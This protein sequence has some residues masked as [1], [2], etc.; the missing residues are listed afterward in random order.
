[1]NFPLTRLE[2]RYWIW[3]I[4][5][6]ITWVGLMQTIAAPVDLS[7][8][9]P[10]ANRSVNFAKDVQP[11]LEKSCLKCHNSEKA[12]GK[13]TLDTREHALKGGD[14]GPD[15]IIG[16]SAKSSLMHFTARLVEDSEMP[17]IGKGDPLTSEQLGI[18]R[19]WI[20]QGVKWPQEIVLKGEEEMAETNPKVE[21]MTLPP[22]AARKVDFVKD[23]QPIFATRC[24]ECHADKKQEAQFRLDAKEIALKGGELGAAIVPGKSE[25]SLLIRAV[26]GLKPDFVMP[27]K[28]ERLTTEQV[29][30]LRAW[31]DQGAEWPDSASVKIEDKRNHWGF[32]PPMRPAVRSVKQNKWVR[33]PID[34]YV[35]ARLEQ[36]HLKPSPEADRITLLRRL[37]LDLIGLPPGIKEVEDFVADKRPDAYERVV[38]RLLGSP[39]YGERWGRHWLDAARY[40]DTNGYEKDKPRSIWPYRDW[41]IKAFNEDLPFDEFTIE[42]LA[43]DLLPNPTVEQRVATGFLRN[44]MLNQEGGIEPEQFRVE[45]LIDRMDTL[46]KSL[47]GLT[48]NCCQCHN[49]KYDPFAQKEYYQLYAFLNND[50]EAFAEVPT[51]GQEKQRQ[52]ILA[53]VRGLEE[54][55]LNETTNLTA[56]MAEW[57]TNVSEVTTDWMVLN[58]KE[59]FNF[60]T[61]YEKQDDLSL[62][63]G[64]DLQPGGITR[65]WVDTELTNITGFRLEALTNPNLMYGGPGLVGKGSFLVKE[66]TV[67][68][69]A[70]NI[71]TVT[72]KI[73]FRRAEADLEAPG[74]SI[75]N[76]IDGKTDKGG[77]TPTLTVE[78]RNEGHR[79]VF[80]CEEPFGFP[81]GTRMEIVIN[82]AKDD[83]SKLESYM[84]GCLRL[85]ITTNAGP[86][87]VDKLTAEQRKAIAVA[88]DQRTPAQSLA[89]FESYRFADASFTNLNREIESAYANWPYPPTTLVLQQREHPRVTHIFK[90]GDR[91]RPGDEV[92]PDVPTVLNPFPK[93]EPRNR[94]GL[95]KWIVDR[96][97]PTTARVIVNRMWQEYFGQGLVTTPEDFGT[98]VERPSHPELLDWLA[99][100]FMEGKSGGDPSS[101]EL[102]KPWSMRHIHRLIVNSATYR[103]SSKVTPELYAKDQF[104]RLLARGPRLR[105]DGE[106]VEDIALAVSGLLNPKIGGPSIYPPIPASVGDTA[107]GGFSWPET[108][109]SDR[110]RRGMYTFSKRSLPFPSLTA[111]DA[112]S[113]E[114]SCPRRVRSNT[115]LQAL[116]TLNEKTFVEAAQAMALRVVKEGGPD[117]RS[118]ATYAFKLCTGRKPAAFELNKLLE[119]WQEQYDYFENRTAAAVNVALSDPKQ[120]PE[121]VNLH[122]VAAWAMV[123]RAILNLD[124]TITK[125]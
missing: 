31:I 77:W 75:T 23:I 50:D 93:D 72:N 78:H 47:L 1:M 67:E 101:T 91:L 17:P 105:V 28:G 14:N 40:A 3:N 64:G 94:L 104:N 117:N 56:R 30:L 120:M 65:V 112:P 27:K 12:K 97:S 59:W 34:N 100:E 103:Q 124:E 86:L 73:K 81:D 83:E 53:K 51:P 2:R 61:K 111:F 5:F 109:G 26:A 74:F 13:L 33:N 60:A 96:R 11:I 38:D 29:G 84:I 122:K 4:A 8:L 106:V 76:A 119:F 70:I 18:L 22:A 46:G 21:T 39:H 87:K 37:S 36:E 49:H 54:K 99:C 15:L 35:L 43:G 10:A 69:Y 20:D 45:A 44:S 25:E 32:K 16:D 71:P 92:Q 55:A 110:F 114:I 24:Y 123:S 6:L 121:D 42:Q 63:G 98:R 113:G 118:R 95:A 88:D 62:L 102:S 125:E 82:Q 48:I 7:K 85:S 107:Y 57:E 90:R 115:P 52:D 66:F 9:P 89:L 19:A 68:A 79:A 58:P 80:E 108:K 116:T 41:V